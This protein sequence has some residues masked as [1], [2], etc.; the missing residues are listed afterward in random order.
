[1]GN[2]KENTFYRNCIGQTYRVIVEYDFEFDLVEW[3]K[4]FL[5]NVS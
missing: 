5:I 4:S 2:T 1:M 3:H